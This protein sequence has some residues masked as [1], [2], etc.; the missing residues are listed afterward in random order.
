MRGMSPIVRAYARL[1]RYVHLIGVFFS[2]QQTPAERRAQI[3]RRLPGAEPPVTAITD[4]YTA[5]R[6]G[7]GI[8]SQQDTDIQNTIADEAWSDTRGT[9]LRRWLKRFVPFR[10]D[11]PSEQ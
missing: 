7:P 6:Y 8:R 11:N 9:I 2:S 4:M 5:E 3:V 1:E 10:R